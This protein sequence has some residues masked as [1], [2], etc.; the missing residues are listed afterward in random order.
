MVAESTQQC[1]APAS[2]P[3]WRQGG[4]LPPFGKF[5][6][7]AATRPRSSDAGAAPACSGSGDSNARQQLLPD[8]ATKPNAAEPAIVAYGFLCSLQQAFEHISVAC[9]Q[10]V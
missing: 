4:S 2:I 8:L 6:L 10:L 5:G 9:Y 3:S 7:T 1:D